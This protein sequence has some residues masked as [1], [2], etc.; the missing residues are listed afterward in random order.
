MSIGSDAEHRALLAPYLIDGLLAGDRVIYFSHDYGDD[1]VRSYA[2]DA[3]LAVDEYVDRGQL[4]II[5]AVAAYLPEGRFDD[6]AMLRTFGEQTQRAIDDGYR[7]LR[8][9]GEMSWVL[10]NFVD[11]RALV[12]YELRADLATAPSRQIGLCIYDRRVTDARTLASVAAVHA[13]RLGELDMRPAV[14]VYGSGEGSV[15]IDG[16]VDLASAEFFVDVLQSIAS[17]I[18]EPA[19]DLTRLEFIDVRGLR[20]VARVADEL[21]R[22]GRR[23]TLSS[24]RAVVK[25]CVS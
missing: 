9:A 5:P 8:A 18:D 14:S 2:A 19:L 16:E 21:A 1:I 20:E 3:G 22:T 10:P 17:A 7:T 11:E 13:S 25:R 23:L 24:P 6:L 4:I 12:D 15:Y